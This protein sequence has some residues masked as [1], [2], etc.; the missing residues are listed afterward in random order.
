MTAFSNWKLTNPFQVKHFDYLVMK[1]HN[2]HKYMHCWGYKQV[3]TQCVFTCTSL[4]AVRLGFS[5]TKSLFLI[6]CR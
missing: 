3:Y 2:F 4:V 1:S 5:L 6:H